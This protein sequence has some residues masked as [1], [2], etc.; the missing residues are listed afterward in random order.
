MSKV[1]GVLYTSQFIVC[2]IS[3]AVSM[4]ATTLAPKFELQVNHDL[5]ASKN[6]ANCSCLIDKLR[7]L[8][9][10]KIELRG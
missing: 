10:I 9:T 3:Q 4:N 6:F 7:L 8:F 5:H 2:G 1:D